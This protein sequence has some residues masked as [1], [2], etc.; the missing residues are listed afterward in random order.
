MIVA[1]LTGSIGMG[2]STTL[3][4][5][6]DAG[7]PVHS[8]DEAVHKLYSGEAATQIEAAFPGVLV[9][10]MVDR[11]K[12]S[13]IVF[14]SPEAL[15][16]LEAI[17][18]SAGAHGRGK[19]LEKRTGKPGTIGCHR[20]PAAFRNRWREPG[21]QGY[22]RDSIATCATPARHGAPGDDNRKIRSNPGPPDAGSG[23]T[24]PRAD[25]V[26]DTGEGLEAAR[27][28]VA[29]IVKALSAAGAGAN[30]SREGRS[31]A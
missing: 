17:V 12:L 24:P 10:G 27:N 14:N 1:G 29:R 20:Y 19:I 6:A 22:C 3:A 16:R 9:D 7:V 15:R 31:D 28:S 18:H 25:Y 13:A 23:K 4:M 11:S 30:L 2:K 21:R 8:A 5:F 26:I